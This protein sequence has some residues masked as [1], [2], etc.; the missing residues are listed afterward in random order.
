MKKPK[1]KNIDGIF[2]LRIEESQDERCI[3]I[4][5]VDVGTAWIHPT[6]AVKFAKWLLKATAWKSAQK[7]AKK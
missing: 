2:E 3:E 4:G 5:V 1:P 6:E 7:K